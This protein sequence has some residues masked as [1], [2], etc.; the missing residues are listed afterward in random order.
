MAAYSPD[1]TP[2]DFYLWEYLKSNVY[3]SSIKDLD[4]LKVRINMEMKSIWNGTLNKVFL[5]IVKKINQ[6]ISIDGDHLEYLL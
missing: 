4:E 6:C 5:N 1:L 2:L 3:K